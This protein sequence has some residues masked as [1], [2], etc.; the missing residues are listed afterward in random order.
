MSSTV[1]VEVV[2]GTT[3]SIEV[4]SATTFGE[5]SQAVGTGL[6]LS[7]AAS[8]L[9]GIFHIRA[10]YERLP[11]SDERVLATVQGFGADEKMAKKKK[12][13]YKY[14]AGSKLVYKKVIQ[15]RRKEL[16]CIEVT[17]LTL[18]YHQ[19]KADVINSVIPTHGP[20]AIELAGIQMQIEFGN[21]D[22]AARAPGFLEDNGL[23]DQFV[24]ARS[25]ANKLHTAR[26]WE[27]VIFQNYAE[28]FGKSHDAALR[29]Y[30][31]AAR[32]SKYYG[33][34]VFLPAKC[35][36]RGSLISTARVQ[37]I[38]ASNQFMIVDP[39]S[40]KALW[41]FPFASLSEWKVSADGLSFAFYVVPKNKQKLDPF[42][43]ETPQAA[44]LAQSLAAAAAE[45][46]EE[47]NARKLESIAAFR[48]AARPQADS[49]SSRAV[50]KWKA[51][52]GITSSASSSD[53]GKPVL[54]RKVV[55]TRKS[56]AAAPLVVD[57]A[58]AQAASDAL[59]SASSPSAGPKV[60]KRIRVRRRK[61]P[62]AALAD[63]DRPVAASPA[64]LAMSSV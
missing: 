52:A 16:L 8:Q 19:A 2:D 59:A 41:S 30:L 44:Y 35:Y 47:L 42:V 23:L 31:N 60:T 28:H 57:P 50:S 56:A 54:T 7:E 48:A 38:I 45:A 49:P 24:P 46:A 36:H 10:G 51:R 6:G 4:S 3:Q 62:R 9:F 15:G 25:L 40:Q 33:G 14:R 18:L 27:T 29:S 34:R 58:T 20:D 11:E 1:E 26:E 12:K 53:A 32:R 22:E 61:K 64:Q 37:A 21:Y 55:R 5:A 39:K 17:A 63:R 13:V 43:L